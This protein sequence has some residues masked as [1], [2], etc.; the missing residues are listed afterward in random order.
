MTSAQAGVVPLARSTRPDARRRRMRLS[1]RGLVQG[2]GFRPFVYVL[3]ADLMLAGSVAT[4]AAASEIEVEGDADAVARSRDAWWTD[5]P[6]L[7][8]DRG[9][10][11]PELPVLGGTDFVIARARHGPGRP[12]LRLARRR[13]VCGLPGGAG[14][15]GRPPLPA[16]VHQLHELRSAASPSSRRCPTTAPP[17]T[18]A[19]V[20]M[21][22]DCAR[23]YADPADRRFHAQTDLLPD[24][25]PTLSYRPPTGR[26]GR[27]GGTARG[28]A[29]AARRAR[30]SPSRASAATTWPATPRNE[31]AV[32]DAAQRKRRGDKPFAVMVAR[33]RRR[34]RAVATRRRPRRALL[35]GP[36]RPDRAAAAPHGPTRPSPRRWRRGSPDLGVMLRLHAAAHTCCSGCPATSRTAASW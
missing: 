31:Q 28:P 1:V 19:G 9:R 13:H 30:S 10:G 20:R 26:L 24:C 11:V 2:V 8:V 27:R 25:G 4:P 3:A 18:M 12:H 17:T 34:A 21:C 33:P 35:T 23:E 36:Q 22:A 32:A 5:A 15:P 29:A 14:R 7:A 16:P 6:P